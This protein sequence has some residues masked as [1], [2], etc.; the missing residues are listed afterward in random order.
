LNSSFDCS[1][2][3]ERKEYFLL[4]V[5]FKNMAIMEF[6]RASDMIEGLFFV[7]VD[8]EDGK[9]TVKGFFNKSAQK[10]FSDLIY[11]NLS[12]FKFMDKII[13][14]PGIDLIQVLKDSSVNMKNIMISL[15]LEMFQND[16]IAKILNETDSIGQFI[17]N[18]PEGKLFRMLIYS[19]EEINYPGLK[20]LD[21]TEHVYKTETENDILF[22]ISTIAREQILTWKLSY[23]FVRGNRLYIDFILPDFRYKEYLDIM[24]K[25]EFEFGAVDMVHFENIAD[26]N[27]DE[28]DSYIKC[29]LQ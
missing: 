19:T 2:L 29:V 26:F 20:L 4:R 8:L 24:I 1:S 5:N 13:V 3:I 25:T 22:R 21:G 9:F 27:I 17:D 11:N 7:N 28:L 10:S 15:P 6:I 23:L 12:I 18:Y 16:R 14:K